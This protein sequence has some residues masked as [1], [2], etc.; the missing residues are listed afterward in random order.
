MKKLSIIITGYLIAFLS[1]LPVFAETCTFDG[2]TDL[3]WNTADNWTCDGGAKVPVAGD[4][5]DL[6]G[7]VVTADLDTIPATGALLSLSSAGAGQLTYD[8]ASPLCHPTTVGCTLSVTTIQGGTVSGF[9]KST[10]TS[11]TGHA[12]TI[13]GTS[14]TGGT[15][16]AAYGFSNTATG[17]GAPIIN[18]NIS[19]VG[20]SGAGA[21][22]CYSGGSS[23]TPVFNING[24]LTGSDTARSP[25]FQ[26]SSANDPVVNF[27]NT[28]LL[29]NGTKGSAYVG[30]M[31]V[32][33]PLA[34]TYIR[35]GTL[36]FAQELHNA[37]FIVGVT[38]G[39]ADGAGHGG[40]GSAV[41]GGGGGAWGF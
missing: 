14:L 35:Y 31:P 27:A 30:P 4:A 36:Y 25:G 33:T 28:I 3:N 5:V 23:G 24:N 11:G 20:G 10:G 6:A 32:W 13:N 40:A 34:A 2:S 1:V 9:V 26:A 18:L 22:G 38:N 39:T 16:A 29:I 19:C 37:E 41:S 8:M 12:L 21:S 7:Y 15:A 17:A